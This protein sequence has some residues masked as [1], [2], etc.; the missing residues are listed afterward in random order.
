M[1][2][3][4]YVVQRVTLLPCNDMVEVQLAPVKRGNEQIV[5]TVQMR[6]LLNEA[7]TAG[8]SFQLTATVV[9]VTK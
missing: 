8:Q 9:E 3:Q 6:C 4:L 2:T 5:G 7:P 1:K